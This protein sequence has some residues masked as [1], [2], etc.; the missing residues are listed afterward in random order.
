MGT[1]IE[2][3]MSEGSW[4]A[5]ISHGDND[6]KYSAK[7]DL[8]P[9]NAFTMTLTWG[10]VDGDGDTTVSECVYTGIWEVS[11]TDVMLRKFDGPYESSYAMIG[12][13]ESAAAYTA[14]GIKMDGDYECVLDHSDSSLL[15]WP[16]AVAFDQ[17]ISDKIES[18]AM[19]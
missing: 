18:F 4:T 10:N 6:S 9:E 15:K 19:S 14:V 12:G 17:D 11:G 2:H 5:S 1:T 3:N 16:A 7:L 13:V 8:N